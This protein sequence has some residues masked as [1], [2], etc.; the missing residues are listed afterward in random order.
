[1]TYSKRLD[2][3]GF[4][5]TREIEAKVGIVKRADGSAMFRMGKTVAYAAVYGPRDLYPKFLQNPE[6]GILRCHYNM[7][8]FSGQGER[9]RPGPSRRSRE[10][11]MVTEKALFSVVNLDDFKNA[12]VDVFI[13]FPQTDAGSR[14]TGIC[15]A[16]LALADAGITMKDLVAAVAI[17]KIGDKLAVDLSYEEEALK[18]PDTTDM[19]MAFVPSTGEIVLLQMDGIISK[20]ELM[21][22]IELGKEA[23]KKLNS[24]QVAALK[25][26]FE[27]DKNE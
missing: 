10:I 21:E 23:C 7:M 20:A 18:D 26:K 16:S 4:E 24:I 12:V 27:V 19:P 13:E 2:G 15:A 17:G 14:C 5:E 1:M 11:G 22:A 8:P 9:V 3:R 25:Q 6:K